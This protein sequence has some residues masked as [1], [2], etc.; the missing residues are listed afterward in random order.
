MWGGDEYVSEAG[1]VLRKVQV[2]GWKGDRGMPGC[3]TVAILSTACVLTLSPVSHW[4][5]NSSYW[6]SAELPLPLFTPLH[7]SVGKEQ[8][9][10]LHTSR[11]FCF[12][13]FVS[14]LHLSCYHLVPLC[15]ITLNN[16]TQSTFYILFLFLCRLNSVIFHLHEW[17]AAVIVRAENEI[18]RGQTF[19]EAC[20]SS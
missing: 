14:P 4:G 8:S 5:T 1:G 3:V 2:S 17:E 15:S 20:F 9:P 16:S 6:H 12:F 18:L 10:H 19:S 11:L 7:P 13:I